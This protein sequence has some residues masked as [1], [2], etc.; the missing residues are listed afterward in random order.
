MSQL[1]RLIRRILCR[2][3]LH[4]FYAIYPP[5]VLSG[6]DVKYQ[7]V[8]IKRICVYCKWKE[9][10]LIYLTTSLQQWNVLPI[11]GAEQ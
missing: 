5:L 4:D 2:L 3:G 7:Y 8:S 10:I 9:E 6:K 1:S 11:G